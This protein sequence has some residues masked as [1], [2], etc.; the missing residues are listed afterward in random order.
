MKLAQIA[1]CMTADGQMLAQAS[2]ADC[3]QYSSAIAGLGNDLARGYQAFVSGGESGNLPIGVASS[4]NIKAIVRGIFD[5]ARSGNPPSDEQMKFVEDMYAQQ[6]PVGFAA[7]TG[8][9]FPEVEAAFNQPQATTTGEPQ[10]A[11]QQPGAPSPY[12]NN[13]AGWWLRGGAA[14]GTAENAIGAAAGTAGRA[15]AGFVTGPG[16]RDYV[17]PQAQPSQAPTQA[18]TA[19]Q[20]RA[21][22][23][24]AGQVA[25]APAGPTGLPSARDVAQQQATQVREQQVA[26][27]PK[28]Q[29]PQGK[30]TSQ[31]ANDIQWL[32]QKAGSMIPADRARAKDILDSYGLTATGV[33][34]GRVP[35]GSA[36]NAIVDK[37][38]DPTRTR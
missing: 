12:S 4:G 15:V 31:L 37:Y 30:D 25:P 33:W 5:G 36:L 19:A 2:G 20:A 29:L 34:Q 9:T 1:G 18:Q 27:T 38:G 3:S 10:P 11:P 17:P 35:P 28:T 23:E 14:I 6:G 7:I 26:F 24:R 21:Q 8:L 13:L 32:R 16:Q 22:Q